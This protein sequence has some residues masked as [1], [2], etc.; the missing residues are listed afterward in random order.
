MPEEAYIYNGYRLSAR[1]QKIEGQMHM[2]P[3]VCTHQDCDML[4]LIGRLVRCGRTIF[5]LLKKNSSARFFL[6]NSF[7]VESAVI[8]DSTRK[9]DGRQA[10]FPEPVTVAC[11]LTSTLMISWPQLPMILM[12]D[13]RIYGCAQNWWKK[14]LPRDDICGESSETPCYSSAVRLRSPLKDS[15]FN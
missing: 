10:G 15:W 2:P 13:P 5:R 14:R 6:C 12:E 3:A 8:V 1:V 4:A 9:S 11:T 7:P